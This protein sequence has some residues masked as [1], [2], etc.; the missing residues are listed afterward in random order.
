MPTSPEMPTS[1]DIPTTQ[2]GIY[3]RSI[4]ESEAPDVPS[5]LRWAHERGLDGCLY[6]SILDLSPTLDMAELRP[7]WAQAD[8]LGIRLGVGLGQ[9]H[10]LKLDGRADVLALGDGD[11]WAGLERMIRVACAINCTDLWCWIG[12][13]ADRASGTVPWAVQLKLFT[14]LAQSLVPLLRDLGATLSIKTHEEVSTFELVRVVEAIGPDVS[15]VFFDPANVVVRLEDPLAAARRVAPYVRHVHADDALLLF[16]G[17]RLARKLWPCG[18]G[19]VDWPTMLRILG[20]HR[21]DLPLSLELHKGIFSMDA[22]DRYWLEEQ[23][24]LTVSEYAALVRHA[25]TCAR[26]LA[27][28]EIADPEAFQSVPFSRFQES[29]R[30]L[31]GLTSGPD[32]ATAADGPSKEAAP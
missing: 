3:S 20:A 13:L 22:F 8:E 17:G 28:G 4:P 1:P 14:G 10:P 24:D 21:A 23:P 12:T 32:G 29:L 26:R 30:Y 2:I 9:I 5:M 11:A 31:R 27:S 25:V 18:N 6:P 7:I 16:Q 15:G 19:I